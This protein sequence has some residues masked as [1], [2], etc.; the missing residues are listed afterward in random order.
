MEAA[1]GEGATAGPPGL[2]VAGP[3][4][5]GV[6]GP[7]G[8]EVAG[9]RLEVLAGRALHW[10]A[11]RTLF[12]ADVHLG[13][14]ETFRALGVPVPGGTAEATLERLSG[15]LAITGA[16]RLVVL[17]D[18]FHSARALEPQAL[19]P[20]RR[21]RLRHAS[22]E[23]TLVRGNHDGRAGEPPADLDIGVVPAPWRLGPYLL[24]HEPPA[25]DRPCRPDADGVPVAGA[26][27]P[28]ADPYRLA[29]HLHP[30]IRVTGRAHGSVRLPCFWFGARSA[31]LPA[32]GE[33][34][35]GM[36]FERRIGDRVFGIA[37]DRVFEIPA[38]RVRP[39]VASVSG[40]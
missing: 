11:R 17:G 36:S 4:G 10:P 5:P 23:T 27:S 19:A 3:P 13:K 31:V 1:V 40:R 29:G 16:S 34:T 14:A 30:V 37:D 20:L 21:W 26:T 6:A 35:G 9:E 12:V 15:L 18:L 22:L 8:L 2:G 38:P 24:C 39:R 32:F 7:L 25:A 28:A 33:F